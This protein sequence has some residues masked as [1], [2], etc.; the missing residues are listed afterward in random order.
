MK[1]QRH[2]RRE[3]YFVLIVSNLERSSRQFHVP[4]FALYLPVFLIVFA[5]VVTGVLAYCL[6]DDSGQTD[7]LEEQLLAEKENV[8]LLETE[9][10][11]LND[12]KQALEM[13]LAALR[14]ELEQSRQQTETEESEEKPDASIPSRYPSAGVGALTA[15]Y[16]E[17]HPY[18]SI[19]TYGGGEIV[20]AGNGTVTEINSNDV[21]QYR[22]K[23]SHENGYVTRY[24]YGGPA[25]LKVE[26]GAQVRSGDVLLVASAD[27]MTLDYQILYEEEPVDP[28]SIIDARG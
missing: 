1:N 15:S 6:T 23:I 18:I 17:E 16:S 25:E 10:E 7:V 3:S 26:E 28:F 14:E 19:S 8:G 20:A 24:L 21:Y 12:E 11:K 5:C 22:I 4:R 27:G 9:K 13:E 2:K